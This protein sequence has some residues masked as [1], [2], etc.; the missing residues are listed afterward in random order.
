MTTISSG[1]LA[2][3]NVYCVSNIDVLAAAKRQAAILKEK[4]EATKQR[5]FNK[6]VK[7]NKDFACS[8]EK[9]DSNK[10][11]LAKD[12]SALLRRIPFREGDSYSYPV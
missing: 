11:L 9:Y 5:E 8:F 1:I 4:L 2:A 6:K 10:K 7:Q 3:D 12:F